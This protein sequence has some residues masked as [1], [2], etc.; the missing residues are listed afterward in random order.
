MNH[1]GEPELLPNGLLRVWDYAASWSHLFRKVDGK[2]KHYAGTGN[3]KD[4]ELSLNQPTSTQG[5]NE[6]TEQNRQR[7]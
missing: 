4:L 1:Y 5:Q 2:W 6:I 7:T 3:V